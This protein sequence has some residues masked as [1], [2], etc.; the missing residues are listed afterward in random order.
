[1]SNNQQA[2]KKPMGTSE[3]RDPRFELGSLAGPTWDWEA[4][5]LTTKLTALETLFG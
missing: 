1:M 2:K 5:I 4:R 3:L